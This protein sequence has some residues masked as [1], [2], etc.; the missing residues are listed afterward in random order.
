MKSIIL[1]FFCYSFC[2]SQQKNSVSHLSW[3]SGLWRMEKGDRVTEENWTSVVKNRMEGSSNTKKN[4]N[5]VEQESIVIDQD[6]AGEISYRAKPLRQK[7][8]SFKLVKLDSTSALFENLKHDFPQRII[9][10]FVPP[11]SLIAEIEGMSNGKKRSVLFPYKKVII[12]AD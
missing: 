12:N 11:D 2:F 7:G 9:Y 1:L 4:N 5:I 8:A 3:L 10:R 6:A